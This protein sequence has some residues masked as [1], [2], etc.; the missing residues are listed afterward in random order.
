MGAKITDFAR[1]AS[2]NIGTN[3][4]GRIA[5]E[6]NQNRNAVFFDAD[7]AGTDFSEEFPEETPAQRDARSADHTDILIT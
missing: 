1:S 3:I 6:V 4:P 2:T 7:D 5:S